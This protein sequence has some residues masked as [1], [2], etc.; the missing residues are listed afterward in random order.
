LLAIIMA[1]LSDENSTVRHPNRRLHAGFLIWQ[2]LWEIWL[3]CRLGSSYQSLD[4]ELIHLRY[5]SGGQM[6]TASAP[7]PNRQT[8]PQGGSMEPAATSVA[9]SPKRSALMGYV[10]Q[11]VSF[12]RARK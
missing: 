2:P 4:E 8:L 6:R 1:L 10:R 11:P 9:A 5:R 12:T 7:M 3:G